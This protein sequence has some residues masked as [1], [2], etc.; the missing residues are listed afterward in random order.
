MLDRL[1]IEDDPANNDSQNPATAENPVLSQKR[2]KKTIDIENKS[3]INTKNIWENLL[4][5]NLR[6]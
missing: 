4:C 3:C 1:Y 6:K 5:P 2:V